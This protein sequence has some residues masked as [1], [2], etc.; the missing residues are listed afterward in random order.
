[1]LRAAGA[2]E[3]KLA[4]VIRRDGREVGRE[5][6]TELRGALHHYG[7]ATAGWILTSGQMLSGAREEASIAGTAPISLFDGLA[8][9]RLCEEHDVAVL[10]A[11]M[12]I[13]I[14]DVDLLEALRAS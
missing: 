14:P 6:V 7:P 3:L 11:K 10:R 2:D 12:P 9:A 13:A 1:V 4:I 8:V 5:R